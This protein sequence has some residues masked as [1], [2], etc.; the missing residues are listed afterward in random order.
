[1][2]CYKLSSLFFFQAEDGIRDLYVTGVQTCALPISQRPH[3]VVTAVAVP[4]SW[5]EPAPLNVGREDRLECVE[6]AAA[7]GI[8]SLL[9]NGQARATA[10]HASSL[11]SLERSRFPVRNVRG[12]DPSGSS[13][14]AG[15]TA[16]ARWCCR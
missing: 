5:L 12:L 2:F 16:R 10:H 6:V 7:P 13:T 9:R 11:A 14:A 4:V 15:S 3:H 1:M 8:E